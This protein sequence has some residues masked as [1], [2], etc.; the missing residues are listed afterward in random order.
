MLETT[1]N[2]NHTLSQNVT[3]S[4]NAAVCFSF[5]VKANGRTDGAVEFYGAGGIFNVFNLSNGT[6][7]VGSP[8]S[9]GTDGFGG[10]EDYG[11]GWFRVH[12]GL[13]TVSGDTSGTIQIRVRD[14]STSSYAGDASK[15]LLIWG[16][17]VEQ[18]SFPT[19]Y[20]KTTGASVT[21]NA[22]VA[23]MGPTT[24]GTELVTNGTFDTDSDETGWQDNSIAST[25]SGGVVALTC[26][27]QYGKFQ[28]YKGGDD[29][30]TGAKTLHEGRRYRASVDVTSYGSGTWQF[31]LYDDTNTVTLGS[32]S[33]TSSGT[34][35]FDFT[36]SGA[37]NFRLWL[38]CT[39]TGTHTASFDNVSVRELYPFEQYNPSE[40]TMVCEFER[41]GNTTYDYVW[42]LED[43][44]GE[45]S[46]VV[47][48]LNATH[49]YFSHRAGDVNGLSFQ[50]YGIEAG[51]P[52]FTSYAYKQDST[53]IALSR[54]ELSGIQVSFTDTSIN[55]ASVDRLG[56]GI[57]ARDSAGHGNC[58]IKR[59]TYY[60]YRLNDDVCD[61]KV[62]S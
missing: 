4:D 58:L 23:T 52:T 7:S 40:G 48:S 33:F 2:D 41:V 50:S 53:H 34:K 61:S 14:G 10:I 6:I 31:A 45:E 47:L 18:G 51:E 62:T 3:V 49:V 22:D 24:G 36:M 44:T 30:F 59:L 60:P 20:I 8:Y 42:S 11:N 17:Q 21:R 5:F 15:G 16:F 55:V 9:S 38:T 43:G 1:D 28:Q 35:T 39:S 54:P 27:V 29:A 57:R 13:T 19:S 37:T 25:V 32:N 12:C 26:S 56:I 46:M